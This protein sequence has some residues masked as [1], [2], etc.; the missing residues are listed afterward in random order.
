MPVFGGVEA[1]GTKFVCAVATAPDDIRAETRILTT[2]PDETL[3]YVLAFFDHYGPVDAIGISAFGPLDLR[4]ESPTWGHLRSTPKAGWAGTDLVGPIRDRFHVPVAIDTDVNGAAVGEGRWGAAQGLSTFV[5][6]TV[7]TGIGG[8]AIVDGRPLHG[9]MHP[10]MGHMLVPHDW[11]RDPFSG[12]CPYHGDCLEGLASGPAIEARWGEAPEALPLEH[13]AWPL[14]AA[15]LASG[16]VNIM[17]ALSPERLIMGGGVMQQAG[18]IGAVRREV[19]AL[20]NDYLDVPAM[21]AGLERAIV[22]PDL[23]RR[24][25]VLG[26][27]ALAEAALKAS[28]DAPPTNDAA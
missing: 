27:V 1:G 23:G 6:L 13:A 3:G 4:L 22:V 18:L 12:V 21:T 17:L 24:S 9:L 19:R 10:E 25:G 11:S 28:Q 2:S 26:A 20:L 8:G 15:Y 5:Y 14:E 7:G 16:V